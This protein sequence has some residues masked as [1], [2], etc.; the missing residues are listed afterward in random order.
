M[1]IVSQ[2]F[3]TNDLKYLLLFFG[4]I[5]T[6]FINFGCP[7]YAAKCSKK[8]LFSVYIA[9]DHLLNRLTS[10]QSGHYANRNGRVNSDV[11]FH[12]V[13]CDECATRK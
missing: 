12:V 2:H 1:P 11:R 7:S 10:R 4:V 3:L 8:R 9:V 13:V 6:T 5:N